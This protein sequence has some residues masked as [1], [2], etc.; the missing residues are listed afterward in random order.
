MADRLAYSRKF[1]QYGSHTEAA[2]GIGLAQ[3]FW[4]DKDAVL[5]DIYLFTQN[6]DV[7]TAVVSIRKVDG[8]DLPIG[9]NLVSAVIDLQ[10]GV[11]AGGYVSHPV[12]KHTISLPLS[13]DKTTH[14]AIV[15]LTSYGT[16]DW[17]LTFR[18][19]SWDTG[20][21][22]KDEGSDNYV[23]R[24][25]RSTDGGITWVPAGSPTG[26]WNFEVYG[27]NAVK[28]PSNDFTRVTGIRHIFRP[29]SYRLEATLGD[30]STSVEL[31][32]RDVRVP[33][34][35]PTKE[36]KPEKAAPLRLPR[37]TVPELI[38]ALREEGASADVTAAEPL[39]IRAGILEQFKPISREDLERLGTVIGYEAPPEPSLWQRLT[40]W[41]EER[42]ETFG[43]TFVSTFRQGFEEV[44]KLGELYRRLFGG[45]FK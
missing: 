13:V 25:R 10:N 40:P 39:P 23:V 32:Q 11:L 21:Y 27:I 36:A 35:V 43:T 41:K 9:D 17:W 8:S 45:L 14:Y 31:P 44:A 16:P 29:G 24:Y 26:Q 30:V 15:A 5:S 12:Y 1:N 19:T 20:S 34:V 7:V 22:P 3:L 2:V 4:V 38:E 33:S 42:G 37:R 6:N 28:Y 18:N